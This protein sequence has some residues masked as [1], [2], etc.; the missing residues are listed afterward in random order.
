MKL[1]KNQKLKNMVEMAKFQS[2]IHNQKNG[3][4]HLHGS[5]NR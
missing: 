2:Y 5:F 1:K 4:P 3:K